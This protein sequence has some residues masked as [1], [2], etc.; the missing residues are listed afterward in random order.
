MTTTA[1]VLIPAKEAEAA[2]TTQYTCGVL[3][4]ILDNF[5][6]TNTTAANAKISIN[7]IP[8]GGAVGDANCI[9]H[10]KT[11]TPSQAYRAYE[12]IGHILEA[13]EIIS[14]LADTANALTIRASGREIT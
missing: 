4:T 11:L 13:G 12:V 9:T 1:T 5:T 6:I 14:T 2:Q 10:E 7:I 3:Q 8:S